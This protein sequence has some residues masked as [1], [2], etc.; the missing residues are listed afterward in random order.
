[1]WGFLLVASVGRGQERLPLP[2]LPTEYCLADLRGQ[3]G[4]F[5][6]TVF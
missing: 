3:F 2:P 5:F 6:A 1:M 4:A